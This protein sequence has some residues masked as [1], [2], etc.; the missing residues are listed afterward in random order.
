MTSTVVVVVV[1]VVVVIFDGLCNSNVGAVADVVFWGAPERV[2]TSL[3]LSSPPLRC[4]ESGAMAN[5]MGKYCSYFSNSFI[6]RVMKATARWG[7][8]R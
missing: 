7:L 3:S 6:W 4:R 5:A 2:S 8:S 1:V